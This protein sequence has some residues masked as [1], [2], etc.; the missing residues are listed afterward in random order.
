MP[1]PARY[2]GRAARPSGR[3]PGWRSAPSGRPGRSGSP[4]G[5]RCRARDSESPAAQ[6]GHPRCAALHGGGDPR[7]RF[8]RPRVLPQPTVD[9][10]DIGRGHPEGVDADVGIGP[11]TQVLAQGAVDRE[12]DA[13]PSLHEPSGEARLGA[14]HEVANRVGP[15]AVET[16]AVPAP[17]PPP[18][19]PPPPRGPPRAPRPP[20]AAPPGGWGPAA[21]GP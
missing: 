16:D 18:P 2:R 12:R 15:A 8:D 13:R 9:I 10:A 4:A 14:R 3:A 6:T 21:P 11:E 20:P 19:P 5:C 7:A 17:P 1:H